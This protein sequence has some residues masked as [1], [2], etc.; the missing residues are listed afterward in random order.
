MSLACGCVVLTSLTCISFLATHQTRQ[1]APRPPPH[2]HNRCSVFFPTHRPG[3]PWLFGLD[4]TRPNMLPAY[5]GRTAFCCNC[6]R[7]PQV[8]TSLSST[9]S[10]QLQEQQWQVNSLIHF[11]SSWTFC[12]PRLFAGIGPICSADCMLR[13]PI[14]QAAASRTIISGSCVSALDQCAKIAF[15]SSRCCPHSYLA[16]IQDHQCL[17]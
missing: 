5:P 3:N 4:G 6:A 12:D 10:L 8:F 16:C 7:C 1:S 2:A 14:C 9:A 11:S 15:L 13:S 17:G